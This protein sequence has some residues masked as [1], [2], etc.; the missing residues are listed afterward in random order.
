MLHRTAQIAKMLSLLLGWTSI[1]YSLGLS[2][3]SLT[4][5]AQHRLKSAIHNPEYCLNHWIDLPK[6]QASTVGKTKTLSLKD[7]IL[8]ALRYNPNIQSAELDRIIQRYQ[9]RLAENAFELQY[10]LAGSAN[11]NIDHYEGIGHRQTQSVLATPEVKLNTALGTSLSL[12][13][14]NQ[15]E[16]YDNYH[17]TLTFSLTQPLLRNF[18]PSVNLASLEN[19]KDNERLNAM[20]LRQ[21]VMDQITAV[22]TSYH[23]LVQ[24]L[25]HYTIQQRQLK[26]A[27]KTFANNRKKIN[28]GQLESSANIQQSYQIE[29]LSL[30]VEQAENDSQV[31]AQNLLQSIGLDPQS[32]IRVE[33][34]LTERVLKVPELQPSIAIGLEHNQ[35]YQAQLTALRANERAFNVAKN[36]QLWQLDFSANVQS[37]QITDVTNTGTHGLRSIYSGRNISQSARVNLTIPIHDLGQKNSLITAKVNLEKARIQVLANKRALITNITN[38]VQTIQSL[39]KRFKLA[40]K[41]VR[42]A[43]ESYALEKKKQQAGIASSLDVSNTQNQL[44]QAQNGLISAKIAWLNQLAALERLL[45]TTLKRWNIQLRFGEQP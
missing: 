34:A 19:A 4:S 1:T 40:E 14:D 25:N 41:Q 39:A 43:Q 45:G 24:A 27:Q 29:S 36:Q 37:G 21:S 26:E 10:A 3:Q 6:S 23:S 38:S 28:A 11:Y 7:A 20:S 9:L 30:A 16:T 33:Q 17:P 42:L 18:G 22:I 8:L 35:S 12:S 5:S 13:M 15:A 2:Q 32:Q 44:I 31:A